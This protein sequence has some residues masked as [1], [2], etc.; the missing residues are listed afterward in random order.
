[1]SFIPFPKIKTT[2]LILTQLTITDAAEIYFLRSDEEVCKYI[3]HPKAK[4]IKDAEDFILKINKGIDDNQWIMWAVRS[5][6]FKRVIGTICLWNFSEDKRKAYIGFVLHP[7]YQ[8]K[9]V[10]SEALK[11]VLQYG[12][13]NIMLNEIRGDVVNENIASIYLMRKFG[14]QLINEADDISTYSLKKGKYITDRK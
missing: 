10:M 13:S 6:G 11:E 2:R 1:M 3:D 9:G 5:N 8:R 7:N 12:F 14:F 4:S